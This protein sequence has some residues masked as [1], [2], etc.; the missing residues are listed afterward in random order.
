[1][2]LSLVVPEVARFF[3]REAGE[4]QWSRSF[5]SVVKRWPREGLRGG[6]RFHWTTQR[7]SQHSN[8]SPIFRVMAFLCC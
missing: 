6:N 2:L 4:I 5:Q 3:Y 1:M 8:V 7:V